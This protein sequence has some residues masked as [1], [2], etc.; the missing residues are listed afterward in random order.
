MMHERAQVLVV[1]SL[2]IPGQFEEPFSIVVLQGMAMGMPVIGTPTGGTPEAIVDGRNGRL[3]D[4][5]DPAALAAAIDSLERDRAAAKAMGAAARKSVEQSFTIEKMVDRIAPLLAGRWKGLPSVRGHRTSPAILMVATNASRDPAN[6]GCV[7]VTRRLG[8]ALE[9]QREIGFVA[10]DHKA[11]QARPLTAAEREV[12]GRFNGPRIKDAAVRGIDPVAALVRA[13]ARLRG[14]WILV[15]E[16]LPE[17][18]FAAIRAYARLHGA[19]LAAIFY[20]A[21]PL[22]R[23]DLC[24]PHMGAGHAAYMRGLSR[25]D[26]VMAIS[27]TAAHDLDTFWRER[28]LIAPKLVTCAL[29]GEVATTRPDVSALA[30]DES[31]APM[32]LCVST[33]EPRKG[34]LRLLRALDILSREHPDLPWSLTLVGNRY[35]GAED[36]AATVE[37]AAARD[38]R[39]VWR[40]IV[41][42]EELTRLYR[43]AAFTVYPSEIEGFGLPV[44]ESLWFG[45]ACL[46]SNAGAVGEL[47]RD[48][49]CIAVD[50]LDER[51]LAD[52]MAKL[53]GDATL[54]K[55][56]S[57]EARNR[58]VRTWQAYADDVSARLAPLPNASAQPATLSSRLYA[59]LLADQWQMVHAERLA[60]IQVLEELRPRC[61]IEVGTYRGGS[62]SVLA[63]TSEVVFSL[64]IDPSVAERFGDFENVRFLTGR[65][66]EL[67]PELL[68]ELQH[69]GLDPEFALVDGSHTAEDVHT[70]LSAFL[71]IR[72]RKPLVIIGHDSN[73]PECRRGMMAVDWQ[74]SPYVSAVELDFV[75][76][77]AQTALTKP[78][79]QLWGGL[80][81]VRM[82]PEPRTGPLVVSSGA[83]RL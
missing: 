3:C 46:C 37:Q 54:R 15:P 78:L 20:D 63:R 73:N 31:G 12:L 22:H 30:N 76:G 60:F 11:R 44:A 17:E 50:V 2:V 38:P 75:P 71:A 42:D 10:W 13:P 64:D 4:V 33:L 24:A 52:A 9:E 69:Q 26:L 81:L 70:D 25:C 49:G 28:G 79:D 39:I 48:G 51:A 65:S 53:L 68:R 1:P 18:E 45:R 57:V 55:R 74:S 16:V 67:L 5:T 6:T 8:R 83:M 7:R 14:T 80:L 66:Q 29:A 77:S 47:A 27:E 56:L 40:G 34:H 19:Q 82:D 32:M 59:G 62:L 36:L 23:P 35:A 41:D 72:P 61:A 58:H 43:Q 21:I